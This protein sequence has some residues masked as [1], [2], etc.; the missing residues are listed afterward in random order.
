M[1]RMRQIFDRWTED[2]VK[3]LSQYGI[4]V[5]TGKVMLF[6]IEEGENYKK[7]R[8]YLENKWKNTHALSYRDIFFYK[9]SQEDIDAAEY[10]IF[11]GHQC[12]GY[13]Q[14][15]SDM[16]YMSLCFDAEKFCWSC[17]CGR[18][19]TNDLRVNKLSK[20]GFWSYCAWIHDQFFVNEK[21]YNEVFAPYGIEKRSVIK[22]GKV[23]ED[24]FQLVIPVIDEPLDLT[25]R[26]HWLC[27][28]CNNIKYDI[29]HKDYPFFPLHE[30]PLPGIYKTKEFFGTD[31]RGW[32][33]S[34]E[35]II[36]K[37]IVN[38]LL[39]SKDLKKEWLIPCR[40]KESK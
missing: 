13:P 28:D 16:K 4:K 12:C 39:K 19:Q 15:A 21:I 1:K 2:D 18:I 20:H 7:V 14:P 17:G 29:V 9:Y 23:L 8:K 10:F 5:K 36:S 34:R 11:T 30:H 33:A 6:E 37:D 27:P 32:E 22:G 38:K 3:Y 26:K 24:V 40:H 35:I 31:P 25:G